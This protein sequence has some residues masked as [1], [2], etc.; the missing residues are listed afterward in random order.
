M[1]N[2]MELGR[3]AGIPI[4]L[5]M[6]FVLVLLVFS[7]PYFT[8][9][10]TQMMSAGFVIIIG[11]L[12]SI[13]LHELGHA[14]VGRLFKAQVS[15][16]ELT[17][18]GG[19]AHFERSLPASAFARSMISLAGPAVNL[20][21]WQGLSALADG[22]VVSGNVMVALPLAVLSSA[23]FFLMIFNLLP[24]YPLD[25]GH[26]LDAWL[27]ALFGSIW[28]TRIVASLGLVVAILVG[29]YA[30]PKTAFFLILVALFIAQANLEAL[31]GVGGWRR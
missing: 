20:V 5:D 13:L 15:H 31:R 2:S 23:N 28:A 22:A 18:L 8:S 30:L 21:L 7:Y 17:G 6:M 9:G 4:Y 11:L 1:F 29:L 10:N 12:L 26:T 24:A 25:G 27:G 19:I 16:I 3:I 14:F